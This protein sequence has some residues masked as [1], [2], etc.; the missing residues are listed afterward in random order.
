MRIQRAVTSRCAYLAHEIQAPAPAHARHPHAS[1]RR[2]AIVRG[3]NNSPICEASCSVPARPRIC[4]VPSCTGLAASSATATHQRSPNCTR[5]P[6]VRWWWVAMLVSLLPAP[7]GQPADHVWLAI[8]RKRTSHL[9]AFPETAQQLSTPS[10]SRQDTHMLPTFSDAVGAFF[11]AGGSLGS[12]LL[13][14]LLSESQPDDPPTLG[15]AFS[16]LYK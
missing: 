3:F 2:L 4:I 7:R 13:G 6:H 10:I 15:T 8:Q 9:H 1:T 12:A 5:R 16:P 11:S 14:A